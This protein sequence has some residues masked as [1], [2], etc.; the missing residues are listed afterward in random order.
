VHGEGA[1]VK[2]VT[3]GGARFE[4]N[5]DGWRARLIFDI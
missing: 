3:Y 4:P 2:A 5:S 1:D